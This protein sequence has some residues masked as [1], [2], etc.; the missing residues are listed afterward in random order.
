MLVV[1]EEP[2]VQLEVL[3]VLEEVVTVMLDP[4]ENKMELLIW[5]V[6]EEEHQVQ[7][8]VEVLVS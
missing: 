3:E 2:V 8:Q 4:L 5:V 1:E 6:E 7:V